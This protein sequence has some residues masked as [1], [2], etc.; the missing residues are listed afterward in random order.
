M[1]SLAIKPAQRVDRETLRVAAG[2]A[3]GLTITCGVIAL[4]VRAW[5]SGAAQ[6]WLAFPF[7]GIP[8]RPAEAALIFTHN[9]RALAAIIGLLL[10]AQS[11]H[12]DTRSVGAGRAHRTI[13]RL[14]EVLLA[15]AVAANVAV[16]G[17]GFG[18]YGTRMLLATLP[19]GPVELG[20]YSL[21]FAVYLEGR[22][23]PI[24]L[25]HALAVL[26][27]SLFTLALAA[28]LETYVNP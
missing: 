17:A 23:R 22:S 21:A 24:A 3:V 2:I 26:G 25:R 9:I 16:V 10:I 6:R 13:Q 15:A 1:T 4:I 18:A 14:G 5:F 12:L 27:L 20:S 11:L 8:A 7:T 28:V 19:H